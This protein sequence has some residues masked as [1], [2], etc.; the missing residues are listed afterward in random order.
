MMTQP[1]RRGRSP[2]W[3]AGVTV[4][5]SRLS[6]RWGLNGSMHSA[7]AQEGFLVSREKAVS[8]SSRATAVRKGMIL[9]EAHERL[10]VLKGMQHDLL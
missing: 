1:T 5:G 4:S 7:A 8:P 10:S 2:C 9:Q 3:R 6:V